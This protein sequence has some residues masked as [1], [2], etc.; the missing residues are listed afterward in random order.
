[1]D[2]LPEGCGY[3][4]Y[5]F[6]AGSYPDSLCRGGKL[7]DVENLDNDGCLLDPME[8]IPCP[9]CREQDAVECWRHQFELGGESSADARLSAH[10]LVDSFRNKR[11]IINRRGTIESDTART[12][13]AIPFRLRSARGSFSN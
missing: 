11:D 8:D 10:S 6:G 7:Y 9:M 2:Q 13:S 3:L 12:E 4:G 1:M 5:E